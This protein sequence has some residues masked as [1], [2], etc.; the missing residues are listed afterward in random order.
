MKTK[1][2]I[3]YHD[4]HSLIKSD[5]LQPIQT[6]CA[7]ASK[8]FN[9]MLRDDDG[10]NISEHNPKYNELSAQY[11]AWKNYDKLDNPDYIGFMH[12]RR[13]FMFDGWQGNPDLCWL[14]KSNMYFVPY[15]SP[16]Y[17]KHLSSEYIE[18]QLQDTD[19][20]VLKPYDVKNLNSKN[21]RT[22]Y[23]SLAKQEAKTFDIFIKTAK[24]LY[25]N[26]LSSIEK[27]EKGSVQYLCNMF[28][29]KKELF[30]EYSDFCFSI[31]KA[32]D[33]KI[34]STN[35]CG[36]ALRFLGFL[37][38]FCLSIYIFQQLKEGKYKIKELNGSFILS[39]SSDKNLRFKYFYLLILSKIT[40]GKTRKKYKQERK[41]LKT[42]IK[43]NDL[44]R[45][46]A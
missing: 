46:N 21:I 20:I 29:M 25:P 28:I 1:I 43:I 40:F 44:N 9:G 35:M 30:F 15:I 24:E 41:N 5:I 45:G 2:L 33:E 22:Q 36:A 38:E 39:D 16:E 26:Y 31:L 14:P 19:I 18:K 42:I 34:D 37:G 13:H 12:Y 8:L 23:A 11:W 4:E 17:M 27:I 6:G 3:S 10:E 7:N 32:V